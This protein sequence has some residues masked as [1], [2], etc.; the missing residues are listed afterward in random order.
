MNF[1]VAGSKGRKKDG[2]LFKSCFLFAPLSELLDQS[3]PLAFAVGAPKVAATGGILTAFGLSVVTVSVST[4][5][6]SS[7]KINDRRTSTTA[8]D[9]VHQLLRCAGYNTGFFCIL[10]IADRLQHA[11]KMSRVAFVVFVCMGVH[12]YQ[13]RFRLT[14]YM[15]IEAGF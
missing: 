8:L 2:C 10:P 9:A 1:N 11:L 13:N 14:F 15:E 4:D 3:Q 5:T 12:E 6:R 7:V